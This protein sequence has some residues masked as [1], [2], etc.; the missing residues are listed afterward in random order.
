MPTDLN[1]ANPAAPSGYTNVVFQLDAGP[2]REA[3]AYVE[4]MGGAQNLTANTTLDASHNGKLITINGTSLTIQLPASIP[5]ARWKVW[6]VNL[7]ATDATISR[8]GKNIDGAAA[9]ITLSQG[10]G[11]Y[12]TT[13][14]TNYFTGGGSSSSGS[15]TLAALTDVQITSVADKDII[16]YK[17]AD[18]KYENLTASSLGLEQTANKDANSGYAGLDSSGRTKASAEPAFTGDVTKAAGSLATVV[19][20]LQGNPVDNTALGSGQ[21]GYVLTWTNSLNK[22]KFV[23]LS[24]LGGAN[25]SQLRG[26]TIDTATPREGQ[27]LV[28]DGSSWK[29]QFGLDSVRCRYTRIGMTSGGSPTLYNNGVTSGGDWGTTNINLTRVDATATEKLLGNISTGASSNAKSGVG[30]AASNNFQITL[31][32]MRYTE[33]RLRLAQTTDCRLWIG[34]SDVSVINNLSTF[35]SDTPNA[36]IVGF[37]YSATTDT[38]FMM[39]GQTDNTH[40]TATSSGVAADTSIHKFGFYYDGS[41]VQFYIDGTNVGSVSTNLPASSARLDLVVYLDNKAVS[42]AKTMDF[43]YAAVYE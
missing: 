41:A 18:S 13:D 24:T 22:A 2:P 8:N 17:S 21:D 32:R 11:V 37:R 12:I 36:K 38:N 42:T 9:D 28:S 43:D 3:T 20:A 19:S 35:Q 15:S 6:L 16:A 31:G 40:Q 26:V 4:P 27:R 14:G 5:F 30:N 25:A 1:A 33:I 23:A 34:L 7:N 29:L 39:V 10:K